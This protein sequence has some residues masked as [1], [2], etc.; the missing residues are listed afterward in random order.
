MAGYLERQSKETWRLFASGGKGPNG[1]RKRFTK[2]VKAGSKREAEK[3]LAQF[4]AEVEKGLFV[5]SA[6]LTLADFAE[7]W[8]R[9][10]GEKNLAPKTLHRYRQL[11][12]H[13]IL[14]ALGHLKLEQVR[15]A[16]LMEFYSSLRAEGVRL[17]GK[18]GQLSG[19]TVLAHHRLLS[20]LLQDAVQWQLIASNPCSR[21]EP[22]KAKRAA[23]ACYDEEQVASM[24]QAL[25]C[26]PLKYQ[27]LI[28]LALATGARRGE[29]MGLEWQHLDT[30]SNLLTICQASQYLPRLG[31]FLKEPKN[32]SSKRVVAIPQ[33]VMDLL[34]QLR[35]KQVEDRLRLGDLWTDSGRIFLMWDGKPMH[36][37]TPSRWWPKF[38]QKHNLDPLPF[39][40]L[41]HTSATLL[42]HGGL[43]LKAI[44]SRLGHA[45]TTTTVNIYAHALKS[46]DREAADKMESLLSKNKKKASQS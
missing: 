33:S 31:C 45:N 36:P 37:E 21:V 30:K 12:N 24:L 41:R 7:R 26:E 35:L 27:V 17:D 11:L 43:N 19:K 15:P 5:E 13:R 1:Q 44:S 34:R 32:D 6:K 8:L 4:V 14:P 9:D 42:I 20:S 3:L 22:P 29:L 39:H 10:H 28:W 46:S 2:T 25:E 40:G 23:T 16:H 18:A 38:L